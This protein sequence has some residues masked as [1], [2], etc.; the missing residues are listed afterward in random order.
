MSADPQP[1]VQAAFSR[2]VL[3]LS[4]EAL[5]GERHK[6]RLRACYCSVLDD[7]WLLDSDRDDPESVRQCPR[8]P[9]VLWGG[10]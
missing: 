9:A 1:A 6:V 2:V 8:K 5:S 10:E 4:G 7:C 3:K